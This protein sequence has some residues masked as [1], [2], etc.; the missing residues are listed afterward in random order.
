[1]CQNQFV[2]QNYMMSHDKINY[3][4]LVPRFSGKEFNLFYRKY[5][6]KGKNI[7]K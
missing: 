3:K 5:L 2:R 1:M 7:I 4:E 6:Y